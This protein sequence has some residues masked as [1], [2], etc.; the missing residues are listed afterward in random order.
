[1]KL[2]AHISSERATKGQGGNKEIRISLSGEDTKTIAEMTFF[3]HEGKYCLALNGA[4]IDLEIENFKLPNKEL[5]QIEDAKN[6]IRDNE[7]LKEFEEWKKGKKQKSDKDCELNG[8]G[9]CIIHN[10]YHIKS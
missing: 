6:K 1:M 2:Y 7:L 4:S 3:I 10:S 5:R 9:F 8:N